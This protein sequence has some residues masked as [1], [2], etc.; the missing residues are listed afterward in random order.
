VSASPDIRIVQEHPDLGALVIELPSPCTGTQ[1]HAVIRRGG[2]L[3]ATLRLVRALQARGLLPEN[4]HHIIEW[5][6]GWSLVL[7]ADQSYIDALRRA[8]EPLRW[9]FG[10]VQVIPCDDF[11]LSVAE[12]WELGQREQVLS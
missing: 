7:D 8:V 9:A 3:R 5:D 11:W 12:K 6:T 2:D 10:F 1:R 4:L